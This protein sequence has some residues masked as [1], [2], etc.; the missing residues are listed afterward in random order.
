MIMTASERE[1][2]EVEV[3]YM[4][5]D[6]TVGVC[7]PAIVLLAPAK[8]IAATERGWVCVS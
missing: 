5:Y 2:A 4:V 6:D 3:D 7:V 1:T 8:G